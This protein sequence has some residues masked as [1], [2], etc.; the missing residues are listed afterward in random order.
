MNALITT[1]LKIVAA[2]AVG[3]LLY[4]LKIFNKE[5]NKGMSGLVLNVTTPCMIF[6]GI[7]TM[8]NSEKQNA[9]TLLWSCVIVYVVLAAVAL[10]VTKILKVEKDISGVYQA[11][12]IFG[13]VGFLGFP[14]AESLY[15]PVGLF[16]M[17]LM[18]MHFNLAVYSYGIYLIR[19]S[20][21]G[22]NKFKPLNLVNPGIIGAVLA[23][24][25]YFCDIKLP[26]FV[27]EPIHFVGSVTSPLAMIIIGSSAAA[28]SLK[29][30]FSQKKIYIM[31]TIKLLIIPIL[32]FFI[33]NAFWGNTMMTQVMT[34]YVGMPTAA[35]VGMTA[36]AA[37]A[38][39]DQA[40]YAT[41]MM[42]LLCIISIP[43]LY[44]VMNM[45]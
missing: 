15:G 24:I 7:V 37:E 31:A 45:F 10:L 13:N 25:V 16:Y 19:R 28:F 20:A 39:A 21:K 12:L 1:M 14:L 3:F 18:N 9:I 30:V 34:F 38:N 4:K 23:I 11:A 5:V 33:F 40:T 43:V 29:K 44:L 6:Y 41:V 8:G 36:V 2:M 35:V 32:T 42:N 22:T 17:A 27:L 26:E